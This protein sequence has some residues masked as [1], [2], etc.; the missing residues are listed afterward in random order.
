M[1]HP[2]GYPYQVDQQL[3]VLRYLLYCLET[4]TKPGILVE[5]DLGQSKI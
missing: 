4:I 3:N 1:G 5:V 2:I